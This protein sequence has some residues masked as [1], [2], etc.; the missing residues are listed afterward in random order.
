MTKWCLPFSPLFAISNN[1]PVF[2]RG[3]DFDFGWDAGAEITIARRIGCENAVEAR[4]FKRRRSPLFQTPW[5][6]AISTAMAARPRS[7]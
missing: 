5:K 1:T 6:P 3:S 4:Y 7:W 2:S